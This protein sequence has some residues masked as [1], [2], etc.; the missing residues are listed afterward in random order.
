IWAIVLGITVIIVVA[1]FAGYIPLQKRDA[2]VRLETS[3]EAQALPRAEYITVGHSSAKLGLQLPGSIQA[4]TEAPILARAD[5]YL[6][7]RMVDIGDRVKAGQA[8][9]EIAAPEID[10]QV[11]QIKSALLQA[12]GALDQT[13]ASLEQGQ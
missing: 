8:L 10:A 3:E 7:H 12:Q 2:L 5:G 1:F 11:N 13:L 9:A 4:I 6:A